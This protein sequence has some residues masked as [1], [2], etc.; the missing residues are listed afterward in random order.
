M[1]KRIVMA[2]LAATMLIGMNASQAFASDDNIP[3]SFKIKANYANTY[4]DEEYRQTTNTQNEWKVNMTYSGEGKGTITT[5]WLAAYNSNMIEFRLHTILKKVLA[6]IIIQLFQVQVSAMCALELKITI[7][8][9]V[10]TLLVD[11][12]MK[13]QIK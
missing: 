11:I 5:Y 10:L 6:I 1:K 8:L 7:I 4:S 9:R 13:R 3:Y 12:G 2:A